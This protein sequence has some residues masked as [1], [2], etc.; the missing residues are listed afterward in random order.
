M[1]P[2]PLGVPVLGSTE[3]TVREP[4]SLGPAASERASDI[5]AEFQNRPDEIPID[6]NRQNLASLQRNMDAHEATGPAGD[7]GVPESVREVISSSGQ[8]LDASIQR[9][10]E[11]RM[12]DS[13]GDVQIHTGPQAAKACEDINARAFTVG[14]HIAFNSGEYDP[15]RP[16]GQHLLAHELAHVRQQTGA[17]ISMMPQEGVELEIDPDPQLEREAEETARRV[18]EGGEL[19]IQ[20]LADTAVHVQRA[21]QRTATRSGSSQR[22]EHYTVEKGETLREIAEK[23]GV[24][25]EALKAANSDQLHGPED[26]PYF[27]AGATIT[28]PHEAS[29]SRNTGLW[30]PDNAFEEVGE[31]VDEV[32]DWIQSLFATAE[33]ATDTIDTGQ[34]T[35]VIEAELDNYQNLEVSVGDDTVTVEAAYYIATRDVDSRGREFEGLV[36]KAGEYA[37]T[38]FKGTGGGTFTIG[39][40]AQYGKASPGT[41]EDFLQHAVDEGYVTPDGDREWADLSSDEKRSVLQ[42]WV[43]QK[44]VGVDCSGFVAHL[45]TEIRRTVGA[46]VERVANRGATAH[47]E[48]VDRVETPADLQPGDVWVSHDTDAGDSSNH[49]RMVS[50]IVDQ[51]ADRVEFEYA[52]SA[53]GV[54]PS[55]DTEEMDADAFAAQFSDADDVTTGFY[56][57]DY[58]SDRLLPVQRAQAESAATRA[59]ETG[60]PE[61]VRDVVSSPGQ[62]LDSSIQRTMEERMGD[63]LGDVRVHTGPRAAAACEAIDARAFTVGNHVAFGA[64]EYDPESEEGQHV[65]AHELAHVRQQTEGAVSMLPQEGGELEIDPDPS[66]EREAEQTA[67]RVMDGGELGV[68]C[69]SGTK[70]YIQ[71]IPTDN[72]KDGESEEYQGGS[73]IVSDQRRLS[74]PEQ[75]TVE[76]FLELEALSDDEVQTVATIFDIQETNEIRKASDRIKWIRENHEEVTRIVSG[77]AANREDRYP[78]WYEDPHAPDSLVVEFVTSKDQEM[79][80]LRAHG[81][82]NQDRY[83][84]IPP[85]EV[86]GI[87][88]DD[89]EDLSAEGVREALALP[90]IPK[91]ISKVTIPPGKA[92]RISTIK[93]NFGTEAT[94][95]QVELE[96]RLG[97]GAYEVIHSF[98]ETDRSFEEDGT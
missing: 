4:V 81:D 74:N 72:E 21:P 60:V 71:R 22:P 88:P 47:H 18:M 49:V 20:R 66:L 23:L 45:R 75:R 35:S 69:P 92:L 9:A 84:L 67:E 38:Q 17:A 83:W 51:S 77:A 62:S 26:N 80:L 16:E 86:G 91:Y 43:D 97:E 54:G 94:W 46:T 55:S 32:G 19:G 93:E 34:L 50:R 40:A 85:R 98:D 36:A 3:A 79:E 1:A 41:L 8:S 28:V 95:P 68:Q 7:T 90:E 73:P 44:Q 76:N 37:D 64:G 70:V 13:F 78:D 5:I 6:N 96:E 27:Y 12:G 10:V 58:D 30:I 89:V 29:A 61:S 31:T 2:G 52:E 82:E 15:E 56:R 33:P 24:S 59:G 42:D 39:R 57:P 11:E 48:I 53:G 25:V 65:I 63:S 87:S 14:N